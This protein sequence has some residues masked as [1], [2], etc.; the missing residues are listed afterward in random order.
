MAPEDDLGEKLTSRYSPEFYDLIAKKKKC[1]EK[2]HRFPEPVEIKL[3]P[4]KENVSELWACRYCWHTYEQKY[5]DGRM[6]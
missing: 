4:E 2:G 3:I 1:D 5:E 6:L